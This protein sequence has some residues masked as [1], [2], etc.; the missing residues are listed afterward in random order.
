[1]H[2]STLPRW[3][4]VWAVQGKGSATSLNTPGTGF[5]AATGSLF[6]IVKTLENQ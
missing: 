5:I 4:P 1:M 3:M 2:A 6:L